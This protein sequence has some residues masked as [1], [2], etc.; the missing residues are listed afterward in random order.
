MSR[1]SAA[2]LLPRRAG[3]VRRCLWL[4]LLAVVL[5]MP[6]P[7]GA[8]PAGSAAA[9]QSQEGRR[10]VH[11]L[12]L[13]DSITQ[14]GRRDRAEY[15]YRYPLY[16]QLRDAGY[17]VDFIGSLRTGL[18]PDASWPAR[19]GVPFDP[20]HEGHYGWTTGQVR[21]R[22]PGWLA[23]YPAS[24]DIVL[25]H[26]GS[27]DEGRWNYYKAIVKPLMDIIATLRQRNPAV[28]VLVGHLNEH[29]R[30]VWLIRQL[31]NAMAWWMSTPASP[32]V[33]VDHFAGWRE[34][35]DAPDSDTFDGSHP[36]LAGQQKM[37]AAWLD[38]MKPFLDRLGQPP[39]MPTR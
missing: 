9:P 28:V 24:P 18:H 36:N 16:Y 26:L 35:P 13:G 27:N 12:P 3:A 21:D 32:V 33:T 30:R 2:T 10:V 1:I 34:D 39:A 17:N 23:H 6:V 19:D 8:E 15:S 25:I 20:D 11:I 31:V 38:K 37:A 7:L 5:A 29:R 22:L 4:L 14:G